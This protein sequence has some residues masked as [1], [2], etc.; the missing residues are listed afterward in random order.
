[1][2]T[3]LLQIQVMEAKKT[4]KADLENK[5]NIF[6]EIG[7]MIALGSVLLAFEWKVAE[8]VPSDFVTV[9]E[10]PNETEMIPVTVMHQL[11]PPPPPQAPKL[12]DMVEIVDQ[13]NDVT[14]ELELNDV[15]DD[16]QNSA[17]EFDVNG[18]DYEE[19][20]TDEIVAFLPSEDMPVFPGNVQAWI[21]KNVR[22]PLLAVENG[23]QG[24]VYVQFVVE[25]DGRVSNVKVVRHVDPSLDKEAVR[26]ISEMP[27]WKPG[28]QR[29]IPVRVSYT[30]PITF[31]LN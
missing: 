1:M 30:L 26:V 31:K 27:K 9:S 17:N 7:L 4:P 3:S 22:Y 21:A 6:L 29:S 20:Y 15:T 13:L 23:I 10:I 16:S 12:V 24:R 8:Q 18:I 28:K 19:E 11:P 5:K 2:A 25:K 14:E